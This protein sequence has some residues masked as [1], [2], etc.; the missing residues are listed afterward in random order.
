MGETQIAFILPGQAFF[1]LTAISCLVL[2]INEFTP[3]QLNLVGAW[4][5]GP[6]WEVPSRIFLQAPWVFFFFSRIN[7]ENQSQ[8]GK[9]ELFYYWLSGKQVAR[10]AIS[11]VIWKALYYDN[12]LTC[13]LSYFHLQVAG[14]VLLLYNRLKWQFSPGSAAKVW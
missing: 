12:L 5:Q 9:W 10:F 1:S 13:Q 4:H 8:F 7:R 3:T 2:E 14:R 11:T 6:C